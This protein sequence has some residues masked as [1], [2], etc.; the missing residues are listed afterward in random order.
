[1]SDL[2]PGFITQTVVT[3]G[4]EIHF[5][6][7]GSG[8]PLLLLHGFPQ[9]HAMWHKVA[10]ALAHSFTV[11][12]ADL[13]GY[14]DSS[15]PPTD[16][17]H[18][19]YSKRAMALDMVE[20]MRSLGFDRF[21]VGAHDRGARVVDVGEHHAGAA[22]HVVFERDAVV[23]G[24]VVLDLHVGADDD[25]VADEHVLPERAACAD[26]GTGADVHEVPDTAALANLGAMVDDGAGMDR[27][28]HISRPAEG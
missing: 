24:D 9:T 13:R 5:E 7:G 1:M 22:E 26:A 11:V 8:P 10:P 28:C 20:V 15:K 25:V 21:A 4:A 3:S 18:A 16:A 2:F 14:G 19:P 27:G 17:N 6:I 12:C 23:H